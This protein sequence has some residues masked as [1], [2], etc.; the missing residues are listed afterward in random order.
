[1]LFFMPSFVALWEKCHDQP[2]G[3]GPPVGNHW[4]N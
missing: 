3:N 4:L 2:M 1:M